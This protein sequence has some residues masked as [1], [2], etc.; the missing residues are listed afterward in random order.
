VR[1]GPA[2]FHSGW[3]PGYVLLKH[4]LGILECAAGVELIQNA[5]V[6]TDKAPTANHVRFLLLGEGRA[7]HLI[8]QKGNAHRRKPHLDLGQ[9]ILTQSRT[10]TIRTREQAT[11]S[12]AC[13]GVHA[14]HLVD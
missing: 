10:F 12:F 11:A 9:V 7:A 8:F 13:N 3:E 1:A 4:Q 14:A 5:K 2:G 6:V